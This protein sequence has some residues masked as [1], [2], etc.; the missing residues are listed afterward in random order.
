MRASAPCSLRIQARL[1]KA[2]RRSRANQEPAAW[3]RWRIS[4]RW[5]AARARSARTRSC[6]L[7]VDALTRSPPNARS[8]WLSLRVPGPGPASLGRSP[9]RIACFYSIRRGILRD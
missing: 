8:G 1:L 4:H 6:N 3:P 7:A 5:M 2:K 9:S